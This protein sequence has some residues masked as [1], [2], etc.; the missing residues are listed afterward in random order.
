MAFSKNRIITWILLLA[1]I[2]VIL[3]CRFQYS[4]EFS[5]DY[6]VK[7]PEFSLKD[8]ENIPIGNQK[9][10]ENIN[11][12][13]KEVDLSKD[14]K[15]I[16]NL[17]NYVSGFGSQLTLIMQTS[18]FLNNINS[19]II[20]LPHFSKNMEGFKYH[21]EKYNN[22]FFMYYKKRQDIVN[23]FD[24]KQYFVKLGPMKDYPFYAG[25]IPVME[26]KDMKQQIKLF[27][28]TYLFIKNEDVA[29][30]IDAIKQN[31]Q[32]LFGIHIRSA[33]QKKL[34]YANY[35]TVSIEERLRLLKKKLDDEHNDYLIYV[36]TD[37]NPY[38]KLAETIFNK[39][40]YFDGI[41][42]TES[43][44]DIM[45]QLTNEESGYKVGSDILNDCYAMSM[46][47]KIFVSNSNIPVIIC[48]M[49]PD[50]S[51]QLY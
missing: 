34:E 14:D 31:S 17:T 36:M 38:L 45:I 35:L 25:E 44:N 39:I 37:V 48:T 33:A 26:N 2:F 7:E 15:I 11:E 30:K 24:Y 27:N 13:T 1:S 9:V 6:N 19:N 22:S 41:K 12:L 18:S 43:E 49:N 16:V 21:N 4:E 28:D 20:C 46:C 8:Y 10:Y 50:V 42:R 29:R 23:L 47:D 32:K 3:H 5:I 51:M 40:C